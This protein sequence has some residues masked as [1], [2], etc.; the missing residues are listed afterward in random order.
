MTRIAS[1]HDVLGVKQLLSKFRYRDC[2]GLLAPARREGGEASREEV[3]RGKGTVIP[4]SSET[5]IERT[6]RTHVDGEF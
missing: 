4:M 6:T 3:K 2:T 5:P 1:S